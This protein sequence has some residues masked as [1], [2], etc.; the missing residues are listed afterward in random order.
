MGVFYSPI[1]FA[2]FF[3]L[4]TKNVYRDGGDETILGR[5]GIWISVPRDEIVSPR[6]KKNEGVSRVIHS[7][8]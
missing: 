3:L 7:L 4:G 8:N 5:K 1:A 6:K 2:D